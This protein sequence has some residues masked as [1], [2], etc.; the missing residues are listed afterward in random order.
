MPVPASQET[1]IGIRKSTVSGLDERSAFTIIV[2]SGF[3][4]YQTGGM[5]KGKPRDDGHGFHRPGALGGESK[6]ESITM[7]VI[8]DLLCEYYIH[9]MCHVLL[10]PLIKDKDREYG[11]QCWPIF[12]LKTDELNSTGQHQEGSLGGLANQS[13]RRRA[14]LILDGRFGSESA[15]NQ[16]AS[17]SSELSTR[18]LPSA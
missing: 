10:E 6:V 13:I 8:I 14:M 16:P 17:I 1:H 15:E 7:E 12:L 18:I 3:G 5:E 4:F 2:S 9:K 11:L